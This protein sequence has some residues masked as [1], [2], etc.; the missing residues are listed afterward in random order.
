[1]LG[2]GIGPDTTRVRA[3]S[4]LTYAHNIQTPLLMID[5]TLDT[6]DPP[7]QADR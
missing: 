1:M 5:A 6:S 2:W 7:E 3:Q 4:P